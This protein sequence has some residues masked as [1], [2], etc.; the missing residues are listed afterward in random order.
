MQRL[1][2]G[3]AAFCTRNGAIFLFGI[4]LFLVE[5][6]VNLQPEG[7][8]IRAFGG[9]SLF[10]YL[11][12]FVTGFLVTSDPRFRTAMEQSRF[13]AL[14][15]GLLTM[16]LMFFFPVNTAPLGDLVSYVLTVFCRAFNSWFWLV[17]MLGF[18]SRYFNFSNEKLKYA[19]EAVLPFYILH[20]TVIV[21]I[22]FYIADWQ[23]GVMVKY[24]TL[25]T[26]SFVVILVVYDLLIRR[27]NT[28][29]FLFGMHGKKHVLIAARDKP[30]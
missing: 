22:G 7:V 27:V 18:G 12:L 8:G 3:I 2:S 19:R 30:E 20:Q 24:L 5:A 25:S 11:V 13:A 1:I 9:W 6:L 15:L 17:A 26:L 16:S 21:T 4:P 14:A 23:T 10:S 28:L 29:R